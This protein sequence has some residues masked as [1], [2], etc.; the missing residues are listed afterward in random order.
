MQPLLT[1]GAE[2]ALQLASRLA[3]QAVEPPHLL[4]ALVLD[5]SR[6]A[7]ILAAHGLTREKLLERLPLDVETGAADGEDAP[8][9]LGDAVQAVLLEARRQAALLGKFVEVGSEHLL[10][11]LAVV[12]SPVR[13]LL[14]AHGL[15]PE[16]VL[17]R[18]LEQAGESSAPLATGI[19]LVLPDVTAADATDTY[20]ILD[21]AAN[22]AREGLRVVEDFVRFSLDDKHLTEVLKNWRHR[23]AGVLAAVD[24]HRLVAA[25][26]TRADVGTGVSTGRERL[27]R[28]L[29]DVVTAN[30]KRVEEAARTLEE[31][32]KILSPEFGRQIEQLRYELYT[33]EKS[34]A[35]TFAARERLDGRD[36]YLL[37]SSELCPHGSGPVIHAALEAGAG[38]IQVREKKMSDR[39][40]VTYGRLVRNWT[41]QAG[42]LFIM[43]DRPDLAV[44]TDADGVHVGQEELSV[45]DARRI[46][47]PSRLV[48]VSTHSLEQARQAVL[49]GADYIG[50]GP[51]FTSTTKN[52][53][54]LAGL[55]FVRQV[56]AEITLPAYAIGGITLENLDEVLACG[57]RRVAVSDAICGAENPLEIASEFHHELVRSRWETH[58]CPIE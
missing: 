2:R 25:R 5:E 13:E 47:G 7:E 11:G 1:P 40:L 45:R 19:E 46:V 52:F 18:S 28:N 12:I 24:A 22:R 8:A 14:A 41:A 36:L 49:D 27:R 26:D 37:V 3:R 42:A 16:T 34:V 21:A 23:F 57:A 38:I 39:E 51:V 56:A 9:E 30:F 17:E 4:W 31:Y 48:G 29:L 20:R 33:I 54:K 53:S 35:V 10:C 43:N 6:A 55:D 15:V 32:G 50:V 58:D 44:L